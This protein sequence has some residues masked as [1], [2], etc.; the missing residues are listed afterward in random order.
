M[1]SPV[2]CLATDEQAEVMVSIIIDDIGYRLKEGRRVINL[3]ANLTIAVLP[4]APHAKQLALMAYQQNKE[5][6]LHMPMQSALGESPEEGAIN[7]EM[8]EKGVLKS[9]NDAFKKVPHAIG[10]NNHQGSL[11]TRHPG[12]MTW[13]MEQLFKQGYF[14]VDSRTSKQSVAESI[15]KEQGVPVVRRSVFLDNERDKAS[16]REQFDRL[17]TIAKKKGRAVGI[18]HPHQETIEVLAEL[19]PRLLDQGVRLVPISKQLN[20]HQLM[21]S[22]LRRDKAK[23]QV[24]N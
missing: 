7:V 12:H 1:M 10:M 4:D 17:I 2:T 20:V 16:I 18:G 14:F 5:V 23:I 8:E 21:A 19:L 9:L 22:N 11:I 15:A 6:M 3:P 24:K 13:V